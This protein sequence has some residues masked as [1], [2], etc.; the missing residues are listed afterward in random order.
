MAQYG[1]DNGQ[2]WGKLRLVMLHSP[3]GY[4]FESPSL[5]PVNFGQTLDLPNFSQAQIATLIERYNI[6]LGDDLAPKLMHFLGGK[7]NLVQLTLQTIQQKQMSLEQI[8]QTVTSPDSIFADHLLYYCNLLNQYP[9]LKDG[10]RQI[11]QGEQPVLLTPLQALHLSRLELITCQ[12]QDIQ[13]QCYLYQKYFNYI[14]GGVDEGYSFNNKIINLR[15][16][17]TTLLEKAKSLS[18]APK[19][20]ESIFVKT[21]KLIYPDPLLLEKEFELKISLDLEPLEDKYIPPNPDQKELLSQFFADLIL[22]LRVPH[23]ISKDKYIRNIRMGENY[24]SEEVFMLT[25]RTPGTAEIRVDFYQHDRRIGTS[26]SNVVV[27]EE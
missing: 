15:N 19:S 21:P 5:L 8:V 14:L 18:D 24:K 7:P 12:Q 6:S 25:P 11:V 13:L 16:E 2:R 26:R 20:L 22:V 4:A 1:G 9:K 27:I 10:I 23:F 3:G 17:A